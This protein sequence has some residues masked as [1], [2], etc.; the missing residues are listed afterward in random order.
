PHLPHLHSFPTRRSSDLAA[1][2]KT[3]SSGMVARK[4]ISSKFIKAQS[5][6]VLFRQRRAPNAWRHKALAGCKNVGDVVQQCR[7]RIRSEKR[8]RKSTRLNSS[9]DQISY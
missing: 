3:A 4:R 8:D 2:D 9:H 1:H 7:S 5:M 6:L